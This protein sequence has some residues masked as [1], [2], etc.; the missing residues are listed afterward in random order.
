MRI[1]VPM[2]PPSPNELRR[3]YRSPFA[4]KRLRE[5][6]EHALAYAVPSAAEQFALRR[7]A[8]YKVRVKVTV[9]HSKL[10]DQD[11][12]TG[13]LKPVLDALKNIRF[14][15]DDSPEWLELLPVEQY[16]AKRSQEETVIDLFGG[17][18]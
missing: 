14:L 16:H 11:N 15:K 13:S 8:A 10:Y 6:W 5:A 1:T 12:L 4:Y 17:A 2:A 3:K 9:F 18:V 7:M